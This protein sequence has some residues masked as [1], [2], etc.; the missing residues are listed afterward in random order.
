LYRE[1]DSVAPR[2]IVFCTSLAA[3]ADTYKDVSIIVPY[4][5]WNEYD[6]EGDYLGI[7]TLLDERA[8]K[9]LIL[10]LHSGTSLRRKK[11]LKDIYSLFSGPDNSKRYKTIHP[12]LKLVLGGIKSI[13]EMES[14]FSSLHT[15]G[16]AADN[17]ILE[18]TNL[19]L[20]S[21]TENVPEDYKSYSEF[22]ANN[23]PVR[24]KPDDKAIIN[25]FRKRFSNGA[26]YRQF[27]TDVKMNLIQ[28]L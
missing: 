5:V 14:I 8:A 4:N 22:T 15:E 13:Y 17:V 16:F 24:L 19:S 9:G 20:S 12:G 23:S 6:F 28:N 10:G 1:A 27:L 3:I 21:L 26:V 7:R 18:V 25:T 2:S 11:Y